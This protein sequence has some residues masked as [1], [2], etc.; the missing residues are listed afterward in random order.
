MYSCV[1]QFRGSSVYFLQMAASTR[2]REEVFLPQTCEREVVVRESVYKLTKR[3][4][5]I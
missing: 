5:D 4:L 2:A 3:P 1:L